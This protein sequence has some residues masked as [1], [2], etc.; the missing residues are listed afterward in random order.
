MDFVTLGASQ[1]SDMVPLAGG[2]VLVIGGA[3]IAVWLKRFKAKLR[4]TI[5]RGPEG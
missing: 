4:K 2:F 1:A 5:L 3:A